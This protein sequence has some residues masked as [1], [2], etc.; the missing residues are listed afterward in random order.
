MKRV[1]IKSD[2]QSIK[3]LRDALVS[4][5]AIQQLIATEQTVNDNFEVQIEMKSG[6]ATWSLPPDSMKVV[7]EVEEKANV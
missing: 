4:E 5:L 7:E 2:S 1:Y 6:I 3:A